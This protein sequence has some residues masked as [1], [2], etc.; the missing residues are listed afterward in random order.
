MRCRQ[1]EKI[2]FPP[3]LS[4]LLAE[5]VEL[6]PLLADEQ[7]MVFRTALAATDASLAH[8]ASEAAGWQA[9]ALGHGIAGQALLLA[10]LNSFRLL[11]SREST[12]VHGG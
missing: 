6:G 12:P 10:E 8:L 2:L 7:A 9:Q 1:P 11:L 3:N 5:P 4:V